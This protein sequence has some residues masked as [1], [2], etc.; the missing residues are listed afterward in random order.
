M[1]QQNT[2]AIS[3]IAARTDQRRPNAF[4]AAFH[5]GR[6]CPEPWQRGAALSP[7]RTRACLPALGRRASATSD[8]PALA[9]TRVGAADR[10]GA[11]F[12]GVA[13]FGAAPLRKL[14]FS[15]LERWSTRS[16]VALSFPAPQPRTSFAPS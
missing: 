9:G 12:F 14:V 8:A 4:A 10:F 15:Q 2:D 7:L 3:V 1:L 13:F 6:S 11:D 5:V 16:A